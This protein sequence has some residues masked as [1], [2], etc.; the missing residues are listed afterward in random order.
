MWFNG[1][2]AAHGE[3]LDRLIPEFEAQNPGITVGWELTAWGAYQQQIATAAAGGTQPDNVF[4]FSNV[5]AGLA[6]RGVL[7]PDNIVQ[8]ADLG[9]SIA[10]ARAAEGHP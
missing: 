9:G 1:K 4:A 6:D 7:E 3:V 5:V 10:A 8:L 2:P